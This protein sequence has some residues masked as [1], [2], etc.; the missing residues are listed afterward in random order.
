MSLLDRHAA[1]ILDSNSEANQHSD[2]ETNR[3]SDSEPNNTATAKPINA[4][5]AD[6]PNQSNP[7]LHAGAGRAWTKASL[8]ETTT[9]FFLILP[10]E[11]SRSFKS[12]PRR[13]SDLISTNSSHPR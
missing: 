5:Q 2:S 11:A 1:V 7:A 4:D 3:H 12:C 6:E 8:I 9:A 10:R 13:R